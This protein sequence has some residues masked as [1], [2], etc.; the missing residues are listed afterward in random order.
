LVLILH[1]PFNSLV[2]PKFSSIF[3]FQIS[4]VSV[5]YFLWEPMFH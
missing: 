3:S 4:W 2:V 1:R 5:Y